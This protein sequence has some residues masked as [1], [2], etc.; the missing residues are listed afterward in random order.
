MSPFFLQGGPLGPPQIS[1]SYNFE[2]E[3]GERIPNKSTQ[4]VRW[5]AQ[6]NDSS[7]LLMRIGYS[8]RE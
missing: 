7:I 6:C 2:N 4:E 8:S 3:N 1:S 5:I